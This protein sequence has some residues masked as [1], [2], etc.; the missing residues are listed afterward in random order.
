MARRLKERVGDKG[1]LTREFHDT[2]GR[3]FP[4]RGA[5]CIGRYAKESGNNYESEVFTSCTSVHIRMSVIELWD[6]CRR[7]GL[8]IPSDWSNVRPF[9]VGY[10]P[11]G[12]GNIWLIDLEKETVVSAL[13]LEVGGKYSFDENFKRF[14]SEHIVNHFDEFLQ[15]H[16]AA[17]ER[18]GGL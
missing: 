17:M 4:D 15:L 8:A 2:G 12:C 16:E 13:K 11:G 14:D 10:Q 18:R 5:A 9:F 6:Y 3:F 1:Y 7:T